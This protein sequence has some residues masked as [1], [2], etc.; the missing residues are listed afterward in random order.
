M[1]INTN[2]SSLSAQ[3]A[4]KNTNN[5]IAKSL[6]KLST[7][8]KINKA[9]D[10]ASG[11]AIADKL[12][13][14]GN[15]IGQGISN[16][17]S[18]V[19][20]IQIADKAMAEQSNILD[21]I[22]TKLIQASTSTT[23]EDGR[24]AIRKDIQKLLEQFDNIAGQT[25]YNG[26]NLLNEKDKEF[27]FQVGEDSSFDIG[28][29]TEFAVN[30]SGL[31]SA[32]N[33]GT[34]TATIKTSAAA[35]VTLEGESPNASI[36][37][38]S[39]SGN[40]TL[41]VAAAASASSTSEM[42]VNVSANDVSKIGLSNSTT[43]SSIVLSTDDVEL[44]KFLDKE[45]DKSTS[46]GL[47]KISSGVYEF[48]STADATESTITFENNALVDIS[49]LKV[50]NL[51]A[52]TTG[53]DIFKV[54]T[55]EAVTVEKLG[56]GN[57][58]TVNTGSAMDVKI[59]GDTSEG[60][61][62]TAGT[63]AML[64]EGTIAVRDN[65]TSATL[66]V[67]AI[68][69]VEA[70]TTSEVAINSFTATSDASVKS[71]SL[72]NTGAEASVIISTTDGTTAQALRDAGLNENA[73]GTFTW[74]TSGVDDTAT[75]DFGTDGIDIGNISFSDVDKNTTSNDVIF[76]ETS[77]TVTISNDK[78]E[79]TDSDYG[80][81]SVSLTT[82]ETAAAF[83]TAG[84]G[85]GEVSSGMAFK[86]LEGLSVLG[87]GDLTSDTANLYMSVVDDALTQLNS[88]RSDFGATQNQ[89]DSAI[90]NMMT[91]QTNIKAAESVIRDVDYAEESANFNKQ[92]IIS[93]AGSYAM[94]QANQVQQNVLRLLQ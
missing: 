23:S 33:E 3:E 34:T 87:E 62:Y 78:A 75:L 79:G 88:V 93:Q 16:A 40:A 60:I 61:A 10:D 89:L 9:A 46:D 13:T 70:T 1:K 91:V 27:V 53:G 49:S 68:N 28:L 32:G 82:S 6:E 17:N 25:N 21:T 29:K 39:T 22:K 90:R 80:H 18:A 57:D 83:E 74:A 81:I 41:T 47:T 59:N 36:T 67:V 54:Y 45:A 65:S 8:L 92:N 35:G 14:Q 71:I 50:S 52:L 30:T 58:I 19:A 94:S 4:N 77:G 73:D 64:T 7:G 86:N 85:F 15:S 48:K 24:E 51:S 76:I 56:G 11:L 43:T 37:V 63:Y 42:T 12:R 38:N 26:L 72:R 66:D 55:D 69:S 2:V 5:N 20:L 84:V 44:A 31:G